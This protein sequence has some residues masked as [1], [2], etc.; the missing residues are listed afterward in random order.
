MICEGYTIVRELWRTDHSVLYEAIPQA[1]EYGSLNYVIKVY[2]ERAPKSDAAKEMSISQLLAKHS[3]INVSIPILRRFES[4]G[5][6]CLLMQQKNSGSFLRDIYDREDQ[7]QNGHNLAE[8]LSITDKILSSLEVLH[9]FRLEGKRDRILHLDLHP[10]NIFIENFGSVTNKTVRFIDFSNAVEERMTDRLPGISPIPSGYSDFSAPELV[11]NEMG[12]LCEGTDLYSV[13]SVMY[14]MM[15]GK[16]Y[17]AETDLREEIDAYGA[18]EGLPSA[19]RCAVTLFLQCGFEYNT[20]YRF[21]TAP[22][23]RK[24]LAQLKELVLAVQKSEYARVM[25]LCY[26]WMISSADMRRVPMLF[27]ADA[28][29]EAIRELERNITVYQIDVPR[30]KYEFDYYW[31]MAKEQ[32]TVDEEIMQ[33]LI[34][35]GISI[36]NYAADTAMGEE[37]REAYERYKDSMPIMEYLKLSARLAEQDIDKCRYDRAYQR[38]ITSLSCMELIKDTYSSCADICKIRKGRATRYKDLA[39][40]Y[41]ATGRC[42]SFMANESTDDVWVQRQKEARQY[43]DKALSEFDDDVINR[44]ITLCHLLHLAIDMRDKTVFEKYTAEYFGTISTEEWLNEYAETDSNDLYKLHLCLR[45]LYYFNEGGFSKETVANVRTVMDR[46][47]PDD[48]GGPIELVYKYI[49]LIL[50]RDSCRVTTDIEKAFL[51]AVKYTG[52]GAMNSETPLNYMEVTAYQ[53]GAIFNSLCARESDT[54]NM[55]AHLIERCRKYGWQELLDR[56]KAGLPMTELLGYE[57]S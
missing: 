12:K 15:T 28:F 10:G 34:R 25:A 16:V 23:M 24:A 14:W 18:K 19:L 2:E 5:K 41:S 6:E 36:C 33:L 31:S 30:R 56:L 11:E 38:D 54:E 35:C 44:Q 21:R 37:L 50:F 17:S 46:L 27:K 51:N 53:I 48:A 32:D 26:D 55:R 13:A 42:L 29:T 52:I 57:Y 4:E 49:G 8:A 9:D 3:K 47:G 7:F 40:L 20:L 45:S 43:F 39:R 22:E 1:E